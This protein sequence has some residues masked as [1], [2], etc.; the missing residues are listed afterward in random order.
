MEGGFK[1]VEV[2]LRDADES[3][4][5]NIRIVEYLNDRYRQINDAGYAV[6]IDIVDDD[7]INQ[8]VRKG[9]ASI[10][11]IIVAGETEYGVNAIIATLAKLEL[12]PSINKDS[13]AGGSPE[14]PEEAFRALAMKEMM[15]EEQED[16][17]STSTVRPKGQD[18][19]DRPPNDKDL[20]S[21]LARYDAYYSDRKRQ[22]KP[23]KQGKA[24]PK[25]EPLPSAK[26]NV[27]KLIADKGY[28]KGEAAF[29]REIAKNLE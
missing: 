17:N 27:E 14:D 19:S 9:I 12:A 7:N 16:I 2:L 20:E 13:F 15:S 23:S 6:A 21:K 3:A 24:P 8:F 22:G 25:N 1:R 11:A 4:A 29:M 18:V 28:D 26:K 5:H 10:P